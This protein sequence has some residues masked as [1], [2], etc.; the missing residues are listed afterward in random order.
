M[1]YSQA[2]VINHFDDRSYALLVKLR[3]RRAREGTIAEEQG[4][5]V[6]SCDLGCLSD[7][8]RTDSDCNADG[9]SAVGGSHV[10]RSGRINP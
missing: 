4:T 3:C 9:G 1:E 8:K 2:T 6:T 7:S 5:L 10:G